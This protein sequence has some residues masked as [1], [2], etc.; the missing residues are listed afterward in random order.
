MN[1][2]AISAVAETIGVIVV[3]ISIIYLAT[4]VKFAKLAAA[5]VSRHLRSNGVRE[6]GFAMA[7]NPDLRKNWV[8]AGNL[9]NDYA[10]LADHLGV[11]S[12]AAAQLDWLVVSWVW[13][14]WGQY[15]STTTKADLAELEQLIGVFYSMPP[16]S[17][18]WYHSPYPKGLAD[19]EFVRFVEKAV[20]KYG[21]TE[22]P[23][24]ETN[25]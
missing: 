8:Q 2:D 4:Q 20:S 23:N 18:I 7:N 9:D 13:L 14:H 11:D 19:P 1:W 12:D 22:N 3:I 24:R 10:Q 16:I 17:T 15:H 21:R 25:V 6:I 5:D